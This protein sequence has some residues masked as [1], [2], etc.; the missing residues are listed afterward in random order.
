[1]NQLIKLTKS[2]GE[3]E[4]VWIN[5]ARIVW[6][7][8]TERKKD[9]AKLTVIHMDSQNDPKVIVTE[10]PDEISNQMLKVREIKI[11]L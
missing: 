2:T 8:I 1:M 10:T 5:P 9:Q 4:P 6:T 11:V 7:E 3:N